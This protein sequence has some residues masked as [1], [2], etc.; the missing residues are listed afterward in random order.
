MLLTFSLVSGILEMGKEKELAIFI[1]S[2]GAKMGIFGLLIR[3]NYIMFVKMSELRDF[4]VLDFWGHKFILRQAGLE[5]IY[6]PRNR[7]GRH[8][9]RRDGLINDL[10]HTTRTWH[11]KR[12]LRFMKRL[13]FVMLS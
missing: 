3:Q 2:S 8:T 1:Y 4:R 9:L 11:G 13:A 6:A 12:Y 10:P 7:E 5:I